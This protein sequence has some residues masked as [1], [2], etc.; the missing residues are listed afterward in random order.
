LCIGSRSATD[1]EDCPNSNRTP[2]GAAARLS[3]VLTA[4]FAIALLLR[5]ATAVYSHSI[6]HP[7]EIFQ[8]GE[9]AHR[10]VY[11]YGVV[12]WE[13][14]E[15][16]R[17]WIFPAFL[18]LI[19]RGTEWMG[20]GSTGYLFG[21]A[22]VLSIIS[23]TTVWFGFMWAKRA[24]GVE[25]AIIAAGSCAIWY[26]LI[27]FGSRA[28]TEVVAAH[29]LLPGLYLGVYGEVL[30]EKRRL[31]L[32]ALLCGVAMSLRIQLVPVAVFAALYFCHR[33]WRTRWTAIAS[34]LLLPIIVFG[35]VD[36][37]TWS[38]PF[39]SFF[40]YFWVNL[41]QA[42]SAVFGIQPWYWYCIELIKHLGP[43]LIFALFGLRRS[44]FLGCVALV[45][46]A[47]HSM[48]GHKEDRFIYPVIPILLTLSGIGVV[49][50]ARGSSNPEKQP[51][52]YSIVIAGLIAC[53]LFS[54]MLSGSFRYWDRNDGSL[55]I[56]DRI[57]TDSRSCG[58]GIYGFNSFNTGG[59]THLHRKI[60]IFVIP[61]NAFLDS[62]WRSF[63]IL[64]AD[65]S[66][67]IT[68]GRFALEECVD[69]VCAFRRQGPCIASGDNEIN[70]VLERTGN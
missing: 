45:I 33:S 56:F 3:F 18:A 8:S 26:E 9:P 28:L 70:K 11:G 21:I 69:G 30:P 42:R 32:A 20:A 27:V 6:V 40:R 54:G 19:I 44:P 22:V 39:Q 16:I 1:H 48:I 50:I 49:E 2:G 61:D 14:R 35:I 17:S 31:F 66:L 55:V 12:T 29:V 59:Y 53:C 46:V 25:G 60:P 64:L 37:F 62:A 5:I 57:S 52:S 51:T 36:A 34:G 7:D 23:L 68:S 47:S 65:E 67:G 38:Y 41:V 63:N 43:I 4:I 24:G 13:W 15:G 58:V 10:L